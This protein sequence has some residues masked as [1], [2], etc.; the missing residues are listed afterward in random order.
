MVLFTAEI[1]DKYKKNLWKSNTRHFKFSEVTSITDNFAS[2]I[3]QGGFGKVYIG[4]LK[5]G[6][7]VAV[8][9]LSSSSRQGLKEFQ[10]EVQTFPHILGVYTHCKETN[11]LTLGIAGESVDGNS[12]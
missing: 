2:L 3:G 10:T 6:T 12:P 1:H 9:L 7:Q 4:M 5:D 11:M 8:K